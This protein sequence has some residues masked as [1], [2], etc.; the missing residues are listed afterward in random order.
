MIYLFEHEDG[1]YAVGPAGAAFTTGESKWH[2][3]GP[4]D[5]SALLE[6]IAKRYDSIGPTNGIY[7]AADLRAMRSKP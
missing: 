4:V 1:R 7:V 5:V 6:D 2:R 3:V